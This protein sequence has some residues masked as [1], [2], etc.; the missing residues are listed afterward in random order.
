MNKG[1]NQ[2]KSKTTKLTNGWQSEI[3]L[4]ETTSGEQYIRKNYTFDDDTILKNE[5]KTLTFLYNKGYSVPKPI[6]IDKD[7]IYMQYV[8]KGA[9]WDVYNDS[10]SKTQQDLMKKYAKLLYD[11]HAVDISCIKESYKGKFV[12]N[13]LTEIRNIIEKHNLND[14]LKILKKLETESLNIIEQ[15]LCFIHRDYHPWN[16]LVDNY[17]LYTIDIFYTQG[18]Y[19]FDVGWAYVHMKRTS[20][21]DN[22]A[23]FAENFLTEYQKLNPD[24][25]NDFE[26]FKQLANLRWLANVRPGE[27]SE[28]PEFFQ[29]MIKEAELIMNKY[30]HI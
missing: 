5:W 9:L 7:G 2:M 8:E 3:N 21:D 6:K 30:I 27:L 24:V 20:T 26:F 10:D 15:P 4:I 16:V 22:F 25:I 1:Y 28:K 13:E 18:D 19:R 29:K 23:N 12:E 11:L 17:K 14:Y